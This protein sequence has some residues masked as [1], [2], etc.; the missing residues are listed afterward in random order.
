MGNCSCSKAWSQEEWNKS[1]H[2]KKLPSNLL[3]PIENGPEETHREIREGIQ[4]VGIED[5]CNFSSSVLCLCIVTWNMNGKVSYEDL[6]EIVG[7]NDRD[8]DLFVVGL[9]EVSRCNVGLLLQTAF[10][11]SHSLLAEATMESLHLYVF[12]TKNSKASIKD[13]RVDKHDVGGFG[14]LIGRKKGA[15]AIALNYKD[16]RLMFIS[17]HL[18]AH[19]H[20]VEERN[21][22]YRRI[23]KSIFSDENPYSRTPQIIV[24]L[25]D[26]NYRIQGID[27]L[28]VRSLIQ[29]NFQKQLTSKDQLL[30]EAEKG[31]IFHGFCEGAL[32]FKPT[33][34]YN[35][36]TSNYD[37]SYK[38][39][40]PSW[41]DRIL[42]KI[43]SF[44]NISVTLHSYESIDSIKGSDHKPVRAHLC[45]KVNNG[46]EM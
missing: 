31:Q 38:E 16:I 17:C 12:G 24:W 7:T 27:T 34:K 14:G 41:T 42:F 10:G 35:V 45:L 33:Y 2:G 43:E 21:S 9:Q 1:R 30:Q 5:F 13:I 20:N 22:Q 40:V 4:R 32:K 15:V 29:E 18:S 28:S 46:D 36:G 19:E 25:G 6:V 39:R 8:Y 26:L 44:A 3:W 11:E 23:S 37:T